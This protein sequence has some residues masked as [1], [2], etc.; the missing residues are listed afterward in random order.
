[1]VAR[2]LLAEG[3]PVRALSRMPSKL[4]ELAGAELVVGDLRDPHSLAQACQG[5]DTVLSAA[6][7]F[8]STGGNTPHTVDDLGGRS[9]IEAA[10][11]AGVRHFVLTSIHGARPDHPIDIFRAKYGV[12]QALRASSLSYTILRP[13]AFMELWLTI[14]GEPMI[15]QGRAMIFGQGAN[16]IN[17]VSVDDVARFAIIALEEP[18]ARGGAIEI[19]GPENL[20]FTQV[21]A[22]IERVTGRVVSKRHIP[23]TAMRAMSLLARPIN[24]AFSRQ[25]ATGIVMDTQDMTYDSATLLSRFPG[26]LRRLEEVARSQ[27]GARVA[28]VD[29]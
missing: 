7:A 17:F 16:P 19:G 15:Q 29:A 2:R 26:K 25:V 14:I 10:R 22:T 27:F 6:H 24:P 18:Q 20:T 13:T 11:A 23:L 21:V 28:V 12:E 4:A 9:L 1:M 8:D 5:V 3:K